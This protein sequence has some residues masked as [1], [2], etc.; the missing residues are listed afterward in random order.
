MSTPLSVCPDLLEPPPCSCILAGCGEPRAVCR[1]LLP[2]WCP[3]LPRDSA[4]TLCWAEGSGGA[5]WSWVSASARPLSSLGFS[6]FGGHLAPRAGWGG[7]LCRTG[8][9]S[10][11]ASPLGT[12]FFLTAPRSPN[13]KAHQGGQSPAW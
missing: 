1:C 9:G 6:E 2:A 13:Q 8:L 10:R 4:S 5:P 7:V 11:E 3:R 12:Y